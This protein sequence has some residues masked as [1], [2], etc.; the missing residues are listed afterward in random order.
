MY[1]EILA[2]PRVPGIFQ[3]LLKYFV[4]RSTDH[5]LRYT[6]LSP[7]VKDTGADAARP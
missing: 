4:V 7:A 3:S 1:I 5:Q 2:L 6:A